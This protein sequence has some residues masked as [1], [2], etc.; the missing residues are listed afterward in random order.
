MA[1][2]AFSIDMGHATT[3]T[4]TCKSAYAATVTARRL[5]PLLIAL[6]R[7]YC[8]AVFEDLARSSPEE[9]AEIIRENHAPDTRLTFAAEI[10]GR[11]VDTPAV[12]AM[13]KEII[14]TH[15]SPLVREGAVLGLSHHL[16]RIGV[17]T[18]LHRA[19]ANDPSPGVR[20]AAAEALEG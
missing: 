4:Q 19:A 14:L 8:Q 3:T 17:Q 12:A 2:P 13:L 20:R 6:R 9:L 15:P 10:L 7:G 16:Q 18:T 11:D 1:S 5:A